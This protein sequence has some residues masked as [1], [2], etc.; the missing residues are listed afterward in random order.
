VTESPTV[1]DLL[2]R[3]DAARTAGRGADA[4][5]LYDA[6]IS[7]CRSTEDLASW[8]RAVLGAASVYVF[9]TE[10]G[11]LPAQLYDVLVRTTDDADRARVAAALARCWA[12]AGHITR[13]TQFADEAVERA[14]RTSDPM[15]LADCLDAAL[16]SHW[17]PDEVSVRVALAFR[18]DEV[19]AH[20]LEAE[21]RLQ[22]HLWGLQVA[23]EV[24][25]LQA[26]HRHMRA[27]E[28]LGDESDRARF[29]AASRRFMLDL[30]RGRTDTADHLITMAT[31]A[32]EQAAL[33]DAWMV[34]ESMK[35]Y[36]AAQTGD[37]TA[38]ADVAEQ[39]E[40]FGVA[41]G[42]PAV[43]AEAAFLWTCADRLD[44]AQALVHTFHG[45]VLDDLP[46]DV[47]WL[48]TLQC[49]LEAALAVD[50]RNVITTA[51][52]LLSPY[53][54]RAVIN[55][56]AVMFHGIT[57][58]TL[59]RAAAALGDTDASDKLRREALRSY[60]RIGASWWRNRLDSTNLSRHSA[61]PAPV[62]I[63]LSPAADGLWLIGAEPGVPVR[64]LRGYTYLRELLR[65]PGQTIS[66]PELV[67]EGRGSAMQP[68]LGET[69]DRT[70][71]EA[72][73]RRLGE[74]D[75]ELAEASEWADLGRSEAI[76]SERDALVNELSA[77]FGLGG[78]ARNTGSSSERA[79]VAATKAIT[80]SI[81]RIAALDERLGQHL[82]ASVHTGIECSYEP[83]AGD[84]LEWILDP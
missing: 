28:Q 18:L 34:I 14:E 64:A 60:E 54:G 27:L 25:N 80:L 81:S 7:R 58:D 74:L 45:R 68:S 52:R 5:R 57:D 51:W 48:L 24:L 72:Y 41:E 59:S 55:G 20:V 44:R 3:A 69:L 61:P 50:D 40:A 49:V 26:I 21:T 75:Q 84:A 82:R 46:R 66:A 53:A 31:V 30:L 43:C 37:A 83:R 33:A 79:R 38:C 15:L 67:T 42:N 65:R 32:S 8:T 19:A 12:Y 23:C 78:R 4:A 10:P 77:A 6:A 35:G 9:G 56:G 70:A 22:A 71:V 29:F 62:R 13:A 16:A 1:D 63:R 76:A 47:N 2:D 39:C 11:K 36:L 17:G 73:R